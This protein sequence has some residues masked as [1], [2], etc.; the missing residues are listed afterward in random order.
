MIKRLT[1]WYNQRDPEHE[2]MV[3]MARKT[4]LELTCIPTSG[5][6]T[7]WVRQK[8]DSVHPT[9]Y[10]ATSIKY[11]FEHYQPEKRMKKSA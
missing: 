5:C 8:D 9:C 3:D 2:I 11:F 4:G 7:L 6:P 10:G 1:F